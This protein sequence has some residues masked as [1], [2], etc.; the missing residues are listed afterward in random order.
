MLRFASI[1]IG[2]LITFVHCIEDQHIPLDA[3][4]EEDAGH[5]SPRQQ[6]GSNAKQAMDQLHAQYVTNTRAAL[7]S[8]GGACTAEN[9]VV[10]KEW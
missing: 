8:N 5:I 9:I 7:A 10:R 6:F 4:A 2:L 3:R 1:L